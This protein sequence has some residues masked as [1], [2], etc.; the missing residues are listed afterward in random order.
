[1]EKERERWDVVYDEVLP[2]QVRR[3]QNSFLE[4]A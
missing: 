4:I 1:M 2:G 3:W